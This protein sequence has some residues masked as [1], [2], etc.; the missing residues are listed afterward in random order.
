MKY[1]KI[2]GVGKALFA[3][4]GDL[5]LLSGN[6]EEVTLEGS[7]NTTEKFGGVGNFPLA[8][9]TS[10]KDVKITSKSALFNIQDVKISQGD[11]AVGATIER[12]EYGESHT[13]GTTTVTVN[14]EATNKNYIA[15]KITVRSAAGVEFEKVTGTPTTGQ[16][17]EDT[18]GSGTITVATADIGVEI[19]L[20]YVYSYNSS[21]NAD[22]LEMNALNDSGRPCA[23][24]WYYTQKFSGCS[25]SESLE[26]MFYLVRPTADLNISAKQSDIVDLSGSVLRVEDPIRADGVVGVISM[27]GS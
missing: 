1:L 9:W 15:G 8:T 6:M 27:L 19:I 18:P 22:E 11:N 26:M 17:A 13:V 14:K 20:D 5:P 25:V 7:A 23:G 21:G 4:T 12:Y 10:S 2:G 16:F 3:R 24:S